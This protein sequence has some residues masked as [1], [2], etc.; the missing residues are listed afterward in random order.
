MSTPN[1]AHQEHRTFTARA[2]L[3]AIGIKVRQIGLLKP[4]F[5]KV[6]IAQKTVKFSPA[7]KLVGRPHHHSRRRSRAG[8]GQ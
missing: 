5:Q 6:R 3:V 7:E 2:T 4:I 1:D 8:G